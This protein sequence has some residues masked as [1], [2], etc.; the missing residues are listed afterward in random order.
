MLEKRTQTL[1]V[2]GQLQ[3]SEVRR[4]LVQSLQNP[5]VASLAMK[6]E[7][8]NRAFMQ[9]LRDQMRD[10][11]NSEASAKRALEAENAKYARKAAHQLQQVCTQQVVL[12]ALL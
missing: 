3:Q 4:I 7:P 1:G 2:F 12:R 5:V 11:L 10:L 8:H 6:Y 9:T